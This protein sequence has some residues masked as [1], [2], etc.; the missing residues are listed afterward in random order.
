[1]TSIYEIA[2]WSDIGSFL[3]WTLAVCTL[4]KALFGSLPAAELQYR[5]SLRDIPRRQR[6]NRLNW[7][8]NNRTKWNGDVARGSPHAA[9]QPLSDA[10][11]ES[12]RRELQRLTRN[13]FRCRASIRKRRQTNGIAFG[14]EEP[15]PAVDAEPDERDRLRFPPADSRN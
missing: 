15:A 1:M 14:I 5:L 7:E 10:E 8:I 11:L 6:I 13:S 2:G 4:A 9:K 12:R 3:I